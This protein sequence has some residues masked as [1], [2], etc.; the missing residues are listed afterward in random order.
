MATYKEATI[1]QSTGEI[2]KWTFDYTDDLPSGATVASGTATHT[3][4]AERLPLS[5]LRH[6]APT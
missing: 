5:R 3:P 1:Q 2:R 4:P 6:L